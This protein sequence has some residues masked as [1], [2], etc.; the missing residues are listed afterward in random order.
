MALTPGQV[1]DHY[2]LEHTVHRG[3][4]T[5]VF[6]GTDL[7]DGTRVA[8]TVLNDAY[9]DDALARRRLIERAERAPRLGYHPNIVRVHSW[10]QTGASLYLVS[11][12][13]EGVSL[14]LLLDRQPEHTPLPL[15]LVVAILRDVAA[16]LDHAE[17]RGIDGGV[18]ADGVLVVDR[19]TASTATVASIDT[20]ASATAATGPLLPDRGRAVR[21]GLTALAFEL[22]TGQPP[23]ERI[24]G[25]LSPH[26]R[27]PE[28]PPAVDAVFAGAQRDG[29]AYPT[30]RAFA[31]TLIDVL[32]ATRT[33]LR[34]NGPDGAGGA[35]GSGAAIGSAVVTAGGPGAGT[36]DRLALPTATVATAAR[37]RSST[38]WMA[39]AGGLAALL[40][41]GAAFFVLGGDGDDRAAVATT[42][43]TTTLAPTSS[44]TTTSTASSTS[45][46]STSTSSTTTSTSTSSSTT[47]STT[48]TTTLPPTTT[49]EPPTTTTEVPTTTTAPTTTVLGPNGRVVGTPLVDPQGPG[50]HLA[51]A[52]AWRGPA[53][54]L[55]SPGSP[56]DLY[57]RWTRSV[58]GTGEVTITPTGYGVNIGQPV[59]LRDFVLDELGRIADLT[60]CVEAGCRPVSQVVVWP[61]LCGRV[62]CGTV[63]SSAGRFPIAL[64][65]TLYIRPETPIQ[66]FELH[67][68]EPVVTVDDAGGVVWFDPTTQRLVITLPRHPAPGTQTVIAMTMAS[69]THDYTSIVY[70]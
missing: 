34:L 46:T 68:D 66:L 52:I 61:E 54:E 5:T 65:A 36:A 32:P 16:A 37:G 11:E 41:A 22:L 23:D 48:S 57:Q 62:T 14:R 55:V 19:G 8:V 28:L 56:A 67:A 29:G 51:A 33:P 24:D 30:C 27:R 50:E 69:G 44:S 31:D 6:A 45:T 3:A 25:P 9:A 40:L 63:S 21:A 42:T 35:G 38:R 43:T 49:T 2:Q 4:R 13:V 26:G 1:V 10:G 7:R 15:P 47:T 64:V 39:L 18:G 58:P 70:G 12:L 59:E 20:A 53:D 60:E 17:A